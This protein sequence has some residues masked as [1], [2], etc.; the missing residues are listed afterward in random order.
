VRAR[1]RPSTPSD[2]VAVR[3]IVELFAA[4]AQALAAV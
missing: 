4:E 1:P 3:E 2:L